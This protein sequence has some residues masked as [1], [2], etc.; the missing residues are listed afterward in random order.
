M[1]RNI[2]EMIAYIWYII[3]DYHTSTYSLKTVCN[4]AIERLQKDGYTV[5]YYG[6]GKLTVNSVPYQIYKV[7]G[8]NSYDVRNVS[9]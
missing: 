2:T 1:E 7:H 8:W 6:H 3:R 5:V 4:A 9:F